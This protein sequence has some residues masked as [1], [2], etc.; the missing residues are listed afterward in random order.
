MRIFFLVPFLG[1][2][3]NEITSSSKNEYD[4]IYYLDYNENKSE[5]TKSNF[6][7][8]NLWIN[9]E[10]KRNETFKFKSKLTFNW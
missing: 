4:K 10:I 1:E 5:D 7:L 9:N 3:N 2:N 8:K 6:Y